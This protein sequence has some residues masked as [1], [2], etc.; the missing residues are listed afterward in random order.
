[1]VPRL[2]KQSLQVTKFFSEEKSAAVNTLNDVTVNENIQIQHS[3]TSRQLTTLWG[4]RVALEE[5][6]EA[7]QS[8]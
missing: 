3:P 2:E 1:M 6:S 8:H 5:K 4:L 7:H